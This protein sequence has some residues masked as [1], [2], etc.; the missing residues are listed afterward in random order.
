M[1]WH[2]LPALLLGALLRAATAHAFPAEVLS[3]HAGDS[4]TAR[5]AGAKQEKPQKVRINGTHCPEPRQ[6]YGEEG[7][8]ARCGHWA[9]EG[10]VPPWT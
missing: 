7:R 9:D 4:I 6:P 3:I 10:A 2:S 8:A 5:R 1:R